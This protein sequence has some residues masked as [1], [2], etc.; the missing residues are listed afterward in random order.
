MRQTI[1]GFIRKEFLQALR[2]PK[3]RALLIVAPIVQMTVFGLALSSEVRNIRL[4][5]MPVASD[6]LLQAIEREALASGWFVPAEQG[7]DLVSNPLRAIRSGR[8]EAVL[9]TP[10]GGLTRA[11]G[12]GEGELQALIDST[13]LIRGRSIHNYLDAVAQRTL[14]EEYGIVPALPLRFDARILYN[15]SMRTADYLVPGV[16][17]MLICI[18]TVALTSMSIAK[19]KEMG[20]F[21]TIISAPVTISE[22][23]IGKT[24]PFLVIGSLNVPLIAGIAILGFGVPMRG[25][26]LMLAI[27]TIFFLLCT[28]S[29]GTLISTVSRNQQQAMMGSFIFLMPAILLSGIMFPTDNMPWP[30]QVV[31]ALDPLKYFITLIRNVMLKGGDWHVLMA[32]TA[33]L[34]AIAAATMALAFRRF[35]LNLG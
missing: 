12:R 30:L 9:E 20:T 4:A 5:A 15:P 17:C 23:L 1:L 19:E 2:D 34:A 26:F 24:F 11:F 3:M 33:A 6:Y 8:A 16:M 31:A 25:S 29:I 35:R 28:V 18:I 13:N 14:L 22:V 7:L 10:P 27:A 21:E 32:N